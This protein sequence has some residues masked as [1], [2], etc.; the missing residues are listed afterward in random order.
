MS[1]FRLPR[2]RPVLD[3]GSFARRGLGRTDRLSPAQIEHISRTVRRVPEV[4][5]KVSGG[6]T[7]S[8]AVA[9]HFEYIDR[10]GELDIETDDGDTL[11]GKSAAN[12]LTGN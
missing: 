3:I 5:I 12:N 6:G 9:A 10:R 7:T 1:T 2:G 4:M 11:H 8:G